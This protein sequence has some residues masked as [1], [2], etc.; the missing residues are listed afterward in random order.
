IAEKF[1][2]IAMELARTRL[3]NGIDVPAAVA[4]LAGVVERRL[5][6][7]FLDDVWVRERHVGCL[8]DVVIRGGDAF[9]EVVV[10][11]FALAIHKKFHSTAAQLRGGI[12]FALRTA[13][14]RQKLLIILRGER[15]FAY[16]LCPER[17]PSGRI[18]GFD[19]GDLGGDFDLF[20][21]GTWLKRDDEAG[22][23]RDAE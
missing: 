5:H 18:G 1:V 9:D 20:R 22:G 10:V 6:F 14:K 23:F 12:P 7:E 21:D 17:L 16:R 15:E 13:G 8:R 19:V 3:E 11:V 2:T 4:T